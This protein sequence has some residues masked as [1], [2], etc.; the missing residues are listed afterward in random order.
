MVNEPSFILNKTNGGMN[1]GFCNKASADGQK[2]KYFSI[3]DTIL[4][5]T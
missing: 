4:A 5:T 1:W 3:V 2:A